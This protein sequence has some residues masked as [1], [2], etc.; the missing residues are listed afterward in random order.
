MT[1]EF[2]SYIRH[3][4]KQDAKSLSQK[5]LKVG[6]EFGELASVVLP[7]ENAAATTHRFVER[8]RILEEVADVMLTA[9]SVAHDM[10]FSD[11]ELDLML[12]R[13][14]E[15]W[16]MLQH[17]ESTVTYPLPYEIHITVKVSVDATPPYTNIDRFKAAC[18][19]V[20]VKPVVLDLQNRQGITV[21]DDVMTSSSHFGTN[22]SA[23][24][25][26]SRIVTELEAL[27]Y[28]IVR[29]KIETVPWHPAAPLDGQPMPNTCYFESHIPIIL[30]PDVLNNSAYS[31]RDSLPNAVHLSQN[32]FKRT[33]DGHPIVMATYRSDDAGAE[34]FQLNVDS[35]VDVLH[36]SGYTTGK[37]HVEFAIYDTKGSHDLKWINAPS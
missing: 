13:K 7:C 1:P 35:I 36:L 33:D 8:E 37:A 10:D 5:A 14:A 28:E 25:E 16:A 6:E 23:Y 29:V 19:E 30:T 24:D 31:L 4:S 11:E 17:K 22:S 12:I 20:G 32:V 27:G 2:L 21:M 26:S 34:L 18:K 15:K 3:L 9:I